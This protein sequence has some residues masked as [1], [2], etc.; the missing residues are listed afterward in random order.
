MKLLKY[1]G[2]SVLLGA[3]L[4]SES[5]VFAGDNSKNSIT[6]SRKDAIALMKSV[7]G[8]SNVNSDNLDSCKQCPSFTES[9]GSGGTL[10]SV[11]YGSFTKAGTREALV[12]MEGCQGHSGNWGGSILLRS[13]TKGWSVVRYER[14]LRSYRCL[15]FRTRAGRNSLVCE[16]SYTQGGFTHT[17][18][19]AIE[20]SSTKNTITHLLEVSSNMGSCRPPYYER[21][22]TDFTSIDTNKDG[23]NDLV[24][25]VSEATEPKYISRAEDQ[26]C[27]SQLPKPTIHQLTFLFNGQ[28]F[29]PT[30]ETVK[31]LKQ[32]YT[33]NSHFSS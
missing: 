12:D 27:D 20:I 10:N 6:P 13:T 28:L 11:I 16:G 24:I 21:G 29:K 5:V 22:I 33:T 1:I 19:D 32:V 25:K 31:L 26:L 15:K 30:T 9:A 8:R 18:L 14:A 3:L 4:S 23:V 7:C 2:T 17:W